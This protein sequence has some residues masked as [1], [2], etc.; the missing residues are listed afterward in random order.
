[1]ISQMGK[2]VLGSVFDAN[3]TLSQQFIALSDSL[4]GCDQV[5][6][7]LTPFTFRPNP[8]L[9][10]MRCYHVFYAGEHGS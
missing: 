4:S 1:M 2:L 8:L 9:L 10:L 5:I 3:K 6:L 7:V